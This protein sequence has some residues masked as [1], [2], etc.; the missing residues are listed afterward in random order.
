MRQ[1]Q[2][3]ARRRRRRGGGGAALLDALVSAALAEYGDVGIY[4][5]T[6]LAEIDFLNHPEQL[7]QLVSDCTKRAS[8]LMKP[9]MLLMTEI[10][11][12]WMQMMVERQ[13]PPLTPHHTQA[14]TVLMMS[15]FYG[16]YLGG[17]ER[18][19]NQ[20]PKKTKL[21]GLKAFIAQLA[22]GEG[23]SIVIAMLA[24]FMA[25]IY[26]LKVHVLENNEGLLDRDYATN[27][28]FYARFGIASGKGLDGLGDD[29]CRIVYV[30]KPQIQKHF[31]RRMVAGKLDE[32][33]SGSVLVVDEVDDLIVNERPNSHYV[34]VDVELSPAIKRA[35]NALKEGLD[36]RPDDVSANAWEMALDNFERAQAAVKDTHYRVVTN[37]EGK[38]ELVQLDKEGRVPKVPLTSG[39]L[40][41]LQFMENGEE[42]TCDSAFTTI[43]TPYIF[44]KYS[45]IFGLTGSVGGKAELN[46]L[47]KTYHAVK[48]D[49]PRFLD[50]CEGD[51]R[52]T[53][54]NHG[55]ELLEGDAAQLKRVVDLCNAHYRK[56]PVLVICAST[57]ELTAVVDALRSEEGG[58]KMPADE[59]QRFSEFDANGASLK[60]EWQTIV[61]DAT[62]RLGGA[63]DHRCRVTVTDKFGGRGHDFQVSDKEAIANGGMLVIATSIPDEREWIQWRGRTARQDK[64]GQFVVVLNAKAA[65]FDSHKGLAAKLKKESDMDARIT[66]MLDVADEGIGGRLKDFA[67]DQAEGEVLNE[68]AEKYFAQH[69]R[70]FDD[71]WPSPEPKDKVLRDF[72]QEH[73]VGTP[74][75]ELKRLA[76]LQLGVEVR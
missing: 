12:Q 47:T 37:S 74:P 10:T 26:G 2:V 17:N 43:C 52:K 69:P 1:D 65:P 33:L 55:V 67:Q 42:P 13:Y 30:L 75:Q 59:V 73:R 63:E 66:M 11:S 61:D 64:P 5:P 76:K 36:K 27:A 20:A 18:V 29:N 70:D 19:F 54:V 72:M 22:T 49:V 8:R 23:K 40:K 21:A 16:D 58:G 41:C 56:V 60:S 39:W 24:V 51:A 25:K 3:G 4:D 57:A 48:F 14:F 32:D 50:T 31:L 46:Y 7:V 71:P 38:T 34:K 53:V 6:E 28:P 62:K 15:H 44:N 9:G 35:Y 45:A 68:I